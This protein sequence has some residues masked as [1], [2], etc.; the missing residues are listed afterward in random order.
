MHIV[1]VGAGEIGW[2]L[3]ER[4]GREH[5]DIV[6]VEIDPGRAGAIAEQLDLQVVNGSGSSPSVLSEAGIQRAELLA[7]VTENDE[8]NMVAS[9]LGREHGVA[10][11]VVRLQSN[12]LRG[13]A[14]ENLRAAIGAD[15]VIDPDADTAD[16]ILELVHATGADEVYPM[17][18][19]DLYVLGAEITPDSSVVDRTLAEIAADH[20]PDRDFIFGAVTRNGT[21]II[22]RGDQRMEA[23]DHVRVLATKGATRHVLELLGVPGGYAR[24][25]MIL[26]AGAIGSRVADRLQREGA[27]VVVVERDPARATELAEQLHRCVVIQ[28]EVTDTNLLA[29]ESVGRMDAVIAAT[30][31]DAS[32]VLACAFAA[33]EGT[34]FTVAVLHSLSLLPLVRRFGINA[35]LS[36]RTA[37]ANAV[38]NHIRGGGTTAVATFL[39]SDAEVDELV[40]HEGSPADGAVVSDLDLPQDLIIGAV[41]RS[42]AK[43]EIVHGST[44]LAAGDRIVVFARPTGLAAAQAYFGE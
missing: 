26:G 29:E 18:D 3:A 33:A 4:L 13:D 16:E 1:I 39:E 23:G 6:V 24:R 34:G 12:E 11:T 40:I 15:L 44:V 31:E 7:A 17:A 8:V 19:G 32:N 2:Y 43:S 37:S 35:A 5:H 22:P 28:G 14:G 9:L 21:T 25:V 27:E 42:G 41:N 10:K 36:P 20:G 30:G 38:L